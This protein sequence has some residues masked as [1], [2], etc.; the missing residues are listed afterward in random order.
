MSEIFSIGL[1]ERL[2]AGGA[3]GGGVGVGLGQHVGGFR[4]VGGG[5]LFGLRHHGNRHRVGFGGLSRR[6]HGRRYHFRDRSDAVA[7]ELH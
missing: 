7:N 3:G 4:P 2:D 6:D 1:T 5:L